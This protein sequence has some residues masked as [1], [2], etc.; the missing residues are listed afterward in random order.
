MCGL[1]GF[2][3][4]D[5]SGPDI[6][7]LKRIAIE[8]QSRGDHAFGLAWVD[9]DGRL[10]MFKRPGPAMANLDDIERCRDALVV[11][12]HCRWATHGSPPD[13]RIRKF[14]RIIPR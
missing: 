14:W 11:V 7:R 13:N 8:T 9:R 6:N 3:T 5:G 1:F 10:H 4:R 2:M 12:G